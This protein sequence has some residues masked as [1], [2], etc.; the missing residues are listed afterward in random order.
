M[1]KKHLAVGIAERAFKD[2]TDLAGAPYMNH[3]WRVAEAVEEHGEQY[4]IVGMLHDLL[5]D[6]PEYK[7]ENLEKLFGSDIVNAIQILTRDKKE[8]YDSYIIRVN[9]NDLARVVK[10][11]DLKDNMD[12]TRLHKLELNEYKRLKKYFRAYKLLS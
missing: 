6:C 11:A 8:L 9:F 10:I 2:K 3:L 1:S 4:F 5:E 12:I 7:V